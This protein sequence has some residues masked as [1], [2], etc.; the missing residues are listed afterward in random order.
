V[1]LMTLRD[2]VYRARRYLVVGVA[3]SLVFTLLYL[4]DG[5]VEQFNQEP[6]L[7]VDAIGA[8]TWV[9]PAGS[10]GPFTSSATLSG[11]QVEAA[12]GPTG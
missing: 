10:S 1:A 4:M 3:M 12:S 7:T 11:D 8:E 9:L 2:M 6:Y 5:L